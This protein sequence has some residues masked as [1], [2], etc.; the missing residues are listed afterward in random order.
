M[1]KAR[2]IIVDLYERSAMC[3]DDP[4]LALKF[5]EHDADWAVIDTTDFTYAIPD[6]FSF[7]WKSV[8]IVEE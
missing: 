6:D 7:T 4:E 3:T 2:Y 8:D 5:A 1:Q